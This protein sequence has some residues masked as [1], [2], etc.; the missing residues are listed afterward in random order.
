MKQHFCY[1]TIHFDTEWIDYDNLIIVNGIQSELV[2]P[3][4]LNSRG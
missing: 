3:V 4:P 1:D 2:D